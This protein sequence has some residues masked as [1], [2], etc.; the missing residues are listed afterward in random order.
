M[1]DLKERYYGI[2]RKL[3]IAREGTDA[4]IANH[5]LVRTPYNATHE[6]NRK[7]ALVALLQRDPQQE[8]QENLVSRRQT[9]IGAKLLVGDDCY[10]ILFG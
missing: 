2:A 1:E 9:A 10:H 4:T 8:L 5:G 7:Q 6:R 3:L